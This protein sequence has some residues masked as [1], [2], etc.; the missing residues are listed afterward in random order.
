MTGSLPFDSKRGC[1]TGFHKRTS[2]TT[3]KGH[4]VEP[5]CVK[6]QTVYSETRKNYTRRALGKQMARLH[7]VGRSATRRESCPEGKIERRG[8]VRKFGQ[9][10][11]QR[12]YTVKRAS[13]RVYRVHPEKKS[14]YVKPGCIKD[15]GIPGKLGPGEGFGPLRKGELKKHGYMYQNSQEARHTAL[16]KAIQEF[17]ALGVFR[18]LDAVAKLSK[19]TVPRASTVFKDDRD[20]IRRHYKLK[21]P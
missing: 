14:V 1:P 10:I 8:Y 15:R 11:I 20:W 18:K 13:G 3:R 21:A 2:Y 16:K 12:G 19:R 7:K 5:R 6:S 9:D 17:G 4:R